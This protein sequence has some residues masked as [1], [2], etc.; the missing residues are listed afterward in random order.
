MPINRLLPCLLL[1]AG[2]F[3]GCE[4]PSE[5]AAP[6][7]TQQVVSSTKP[8]DATAAGSA[9]APPAESKALRW[10]FRPGDVY[11]WSAH[12]GMD[13]DLP[14][15]KDRTQVIT[16]SK[17]DFDVK[18]IMVTEI[19]S[20]L[21]FTL[22]RVRMRIEGIP[23]QDLE[24]DKPKPFI[25]EYDSLADGKGQVDQSSYYLLDRP[26]TVIA[27]ASGK[28]STI[29]ADADVP[30]ILKIVRDRQTASLMYEPEA[31]NSFYFNGLLELPMAEPEVGND[32]K[33]SITSPKPLGLSSWE[34]GFTARYEGLVEEEDVPL[35]R[36]TITP[37]FEFPENA[38]PIVRF[39]EQKSD[40]EMFFDR[41]QGL[42]VSSRWKAD[43]ELLLANSDVPGRMIMT[44]N[45]T[46]K[47][48]TSDDK[49]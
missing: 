18:P 36:F 6:S 25:M 42:M 35:E 49:P 43:C 31:M 12:W 44:N 33:Q 22:V 46:W 45:S 1:I 47:K 4:S 14:E 28:I 20:I 30:T 9:E 21:K 48:K 11:R 2:V 26:F 39:G 5:P 32:W 34:M 23:L 10:K 8:T 7:N 13:L 16:T 41:K 19:Q 37:K 15:G 24:A 17:L 40:G 3:V 38:L 27:N 29:N